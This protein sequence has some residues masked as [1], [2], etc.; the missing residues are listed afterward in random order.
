MVVLQRSVWG[1]VSAVFFAEGTGAR[2]MSSG[3]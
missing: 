2:Q 1:Y 3:A